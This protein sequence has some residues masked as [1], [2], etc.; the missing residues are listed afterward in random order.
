MWKGARTGASMSATLES[1]GPS[2]VPRRYLRVAEPRPLRLAL[3]W[4][5]VGILNPIQLVWLFAGR[6]NT[7]LP[8][9]PSSMFWLIGLPAS[10]A[11]AAC[12]PS[13]LGRTIVPTQFPW[14]L[15]LKGWLG[16]S[17]VA[18]G[19]PALFSAFSGIEAFLLV[20]FFGGVIALIVGLPAA[21]VGGLLF[22]L[23]VFRAVRVDPQL[24][25][26]DPQIDPARIVAAFEAGQVV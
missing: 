14:T 7:A 4:L 1:C 18:I 24:L 13:L 5:L 10:V 17:L 2:R 11:A 8:V 23:V 12:V 16:T 3:A 26:C 20:A 9:D 6:L 19:L 25:S 15:S 22:R 21:L